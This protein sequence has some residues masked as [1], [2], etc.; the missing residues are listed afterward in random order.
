MMS[1]CMPGM[2]MKNPNRAE[3]SAA[4]PAGVSDGKQA[5]RLRPVLVPG[6]LCEPHPAPN[7]PNRHQWSDSR[8]AMG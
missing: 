1:K 2:G 8:M 5:A 4:P 6:K 3:G 7:T